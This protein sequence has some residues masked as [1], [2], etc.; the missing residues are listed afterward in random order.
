MSH[1]VT[2]H[3]DARGL[4]EAEAHHDDVHGA[5]PAGVPVRVEEHVR[6]VGLERREFRRISRVAVLV[7]CVGKSQDK[8]SHQ[9]RRPGDLTVFAG[10]Q[11]SCD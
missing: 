11:V 9:T 4:P 8:G 1:H 5:H 6:D 10:K 3:E 2:C 7:A